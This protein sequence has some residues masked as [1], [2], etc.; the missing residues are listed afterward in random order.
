MTSILAYLTDFN[1]D[2]HMAFYD[3]LLQA[4]EK[5]RNTLLSLPFITHGARGQVN[6][7]AYIAF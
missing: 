3:T 2:K 4:T 6:V 7:E 1:E 5:E